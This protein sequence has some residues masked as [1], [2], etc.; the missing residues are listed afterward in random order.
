MIPRWLPR[1]SQPQRGTLR[2][3]DQSARY[4]IVEQGGDGQQHLHIGAERDQIS[5]HTGRH[6]GRLTR[7]G[8]DVW[9]SNGRPDHLIGRAKRSLKTLGVEQIGLW[10]LHR[11]DPRVP[12]DDQFGAIRQVLDAGILRNA[13]LSEVSVEEIKAT[14]KVFPVATVQNRYNLIDRGS[15]DVLEYCTANRLGL[16]PW[17]PLAEGCLTR[18]GGA[19]DRIAK[20]HDAHAGQVAL[21]WLLQR[22][23]VV[24]PIPGRLRAAHLEETSVAAGLSLSSREVAE[25]G[26]AAEPLFCPGL[27]PGRNRSNLRALTRW[28][29]LGDRG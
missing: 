11:I 23:P 4:A 29:V 18:P 3:H 16:I 27:A 8:P 13:G 21:A 15:D 19:V 26:A 5:P 9:T 25:L 10:Q 20:A 22:S 28:G 7:S 14:G 1:L 12:R 24:L 2:R 17:C 6:Q